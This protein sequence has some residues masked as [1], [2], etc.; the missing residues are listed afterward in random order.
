VVR[1]GTSFPLKLLENS[2]KHVKERWKENLDPR[3]E[4]EDKK[5]TEEQL[6]IVNCHGRSI[7]IAHVRCWIIA[8][9]PRT[10]FVGGVIS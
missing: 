3:D 4:G 2:S 10:K 9:F 6:A 5:P 1:T 7:L 8:S